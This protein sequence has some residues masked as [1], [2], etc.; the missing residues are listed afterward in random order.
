MW[1]YEPIYTSV[2]SKFLINIPILNDYSLFLDTVMRLPRDYDDDPRMF[3]HRNMFG[4][5]NAELIHET[6]QSLYSRVFRKYSS[7]FR[8]ENKVKE[9]EH[10]EEIFAPGHR[11]TY[12][13]TQEELLRIGKQ[14]VDISVQTGG[15]LEMAAFDEDGEFHITRDN[16]TLRYDKDTKERAVVKPNDPPIMIHDSLITLD[17]PL[18]EDELSLLR[19]FRGSRSNS[20]ESITI[21]ERHEKTKLDFDTG[22][23]TIAEK[24]I[25][26]IIY[27]GEIKA[28]PGPSRVKV[29]Q[30]PKLRPT[31]QARRQIRFEEATTMILPKDLSDENDQ[32]KPVEHERGELSL[33]QTKTWRNQHLSSI[34]EDNES[35]MKHRHFWERQGKKSKKKANI[36]QL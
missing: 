22:A 9:D 1:Q 14:T 11:K 6:K 16:K 18:P 28:M 2:S 35:G 20:T 31:S 4:G 23:A 26:S 10:E 25:S 33:G 13:F 3:Y 19:F 27:D 29:K 7:C 12:S 36:S 24:E 21:K 5:G 34:K 8:K 32:D 17:E 30:K 15:S